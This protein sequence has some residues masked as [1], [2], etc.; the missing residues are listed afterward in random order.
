VFGPGQFYQRPYSP[1]WDVVLY[2]LGN[3]VLYFS[4][5]SGESGRSTRKHVGQFLAQLKELADEETFYVSL[6]SLSLT[7]TTFTWYAALPFNSIKNM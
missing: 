6:F 7:G 2:P 4:K 3:S 5:F 1:I